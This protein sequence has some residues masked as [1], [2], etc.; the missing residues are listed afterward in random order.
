MYFLLNYGTQLECLNFSFYLF[1]FVLNFV[2]IFILSSNTYILFKNFSCIFYFVFPDD[3]NKNMFSVE[4][5]T[6]TICD[7]PI[8]PQVR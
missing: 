1:I 6:S 2:T 5:K 3:I 8:N 7:K 4:I